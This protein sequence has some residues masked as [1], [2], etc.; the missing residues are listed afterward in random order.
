VPAQCNGL[1]LDSTHVRRSLPPDVR[2]QQATVNL[3]RIWRAALNVAAGAGAGF[4]IGRTLSRHVR[5]FFACSW[6]I[7]AAGRR[8]DYF[9]QRRGRRGSVVGGVEVS[10]DG[11]T[12]WRP[13]IGRDTWSYSWVPI[14]SGVVQLKARSIDDSGNVE[15]PEAG[16]P[17]MLRCRRI[18]VR[19][20]S[21]LVSRAAGSRGQ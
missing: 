3:L 6:R 19:A 12:T 13:A 11:G 2:M 4:S 20:A 7:A 21:E 16:P 17:S 1:G 15:M 18:L 10:V 14:T 9:W 8:R 5:D